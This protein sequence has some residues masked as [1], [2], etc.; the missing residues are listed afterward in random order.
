MAHLDGLTGIANRRAWDLGIA[1]ALRVAARTGA[2][3]AVAL[4]DLDHF[5]QFNDTNGHLLGDRLLREAAAAWR[6]QLREGDLLARYGGEEFAVLLP[7]AS[8]DD[9]IQVVDRMRAVTPYR[10]SFSAGI[11]R[12]DGT[13]SAEALTARADGKLYEAKHA[14]RN[15]TVAADVA[16]AR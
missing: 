12:W 7:G 1:D 2:P 13:E 8:L 9:A 3:P 16:L 6:V 5:K 15:R 14:G 11:V 4:L 10:Q